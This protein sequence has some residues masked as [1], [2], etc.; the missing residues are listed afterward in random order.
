M[1]LNVYD[2]IVRIPDDIEIN[3]FALKL[4]G[5]TKEKS[6]VEGVECSKV[7]DKFMLDIE[8]VDMI[9]AHNIKFDIDMIKVALMRLAKSST[10]YKKHLDKIQSYVNKNIF[11]CTQMSTTEYCNLTVTRANGTS[12]AKMPKLKELYKILFNEEVSEHKLHNSLI[13]TILCL[14]CYIMFNHSV[15]IY[16]I[17]RIHG[18]LMDLIS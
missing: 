3:E 17:E 2:N 13:D 5:V 12:Y 4:H 16:N 11:Y 1:I 9:I 8:D 10:I 14:R 6:L 7:L 18:L 15:D